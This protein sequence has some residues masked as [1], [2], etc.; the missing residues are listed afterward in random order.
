M[1]QTPINDET[2]VA[3]LDGELPHEQHVHIT[4]HLQVSPDLRQRVSALQASWDLLGDLPCTTPR[5][6]LAQSTIEVVTLA[7]QQEARSW[8]GWLAAYRWLAVGLGGLLMLAGGMATGKVRTEYLTRQLL[9]NLPVIVDY[10]SLK[11]IDSVEFLRALAEIDNLT[12]AAGSHATRTIIGDGKVPAKIADKRTWVANLEEASRGRLRNHLEEYKQPMDGPR[13]ASLRAIAQE[14]V[15]KPD[16]TAHYLETIRAYRAILEAWGEKAKRA[17]LTGPVDERIAAIKARVSVELVLNHVPTAEDRQAFREWMD[18]F[19]DR[20]ENMSQY[21]IYTDSQII[22]DLL[23]GD[24][25][26]SIVSKQDMDDLIKNRLSPTTAKLLMNI[27][28][29]SARRY[30][31]GLWISSPVPADRSNGV[32]D[33]QEAFSELPEQRQNEFEFLPEEEVRK[34]LLRRATEPAAATA[35]QSIY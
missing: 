35:P 26:N 13:K 31:L 32:K 17:L 2:L 8:T 24:P 6:D 7:I 22:S 28:D 30:H 20:E 16:R 18:L 25:E 11:Y 29:E 3:F 5:Q 19:I 10:P 1:M 4:Q 33:L 14:I 12:L 9:A 23:S 21:F 15:D 27:T 34:R